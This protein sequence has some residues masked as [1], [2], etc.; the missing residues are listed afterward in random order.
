MSTSDI[1]IKLALEGGQ[2]LKT[3]IRDAGLSMR[4]LGSELKKISSQMALTKNKQ[5]LMKQSVQNLGK[6]FNTQKGNVKLVNQQFTE[7]KQ[8][9]DALEKEY[10]ELASAQGENSKETQQAKEKWLEASRNVDRYSQKLNQAETKLNQIELELRQTQQELIKTNIEESKFG[11]INST[12]TGIQPRLNAVAN[13]FM[14]ITKAITGVAMGLVGLSL[15]KA[16]AKLETL[17]EVRA[18]FK[19]LGKDTKEIQR[20]MDA[21]SNS[22]TGTKY[23]MA[24]M[25][26][27]SKGADASIGNYSMSMEDYLSRIADISAFTG[28]SVTQTGTM[29][30]KAM[31]KNRVDARLMNQLI[32]AGIPIYDDLARVTGKSTAEISEMVSAGQIGFEDL[33]KATERYKDLA[34]ELGM[35]TLKG[36]GTILAQTWGNVGVAFLEGAYEPMRK[37]LTNIVLWLK[38]NMDQIKEWGASFGNAINYLINYVRTGEKDMKGL[39]GVA[40]KIAGTLRPFITIVA[41]LV[42]AFMNLST[43]GKVAVLMIATFTA[44]VLKLA[45][46]M[47]TLSNNIQKCYTSFMKHA[48][49]VTFDA[50]ATEVSN[51]EIRRAYIER[52]KENLATVK[53][54]VAKGL[55]TVATTSM[56]VATRI[57][58]TAQRM[59]NRVMMMNPYVLVAGAILTV[60]SALGIFLASNEEARAKVSSFFSGFIKNAKTIAKNFPETMDSIVEALSETLP[61]MVSAGSEMI[62]SIVEGFMQNL[63]TMVEMGTQ[64]IVKLIEGFATALPNMVAGIT[65]MI[66]QFAIIIT[67]NLPLIINAGLKILMSLIQGI[68]TALPMLIISAI[69]I[70]T[71]LIQGIG[72]M[73][74]TILATG[75]KL[76]MAI[77]KGIIQTIPVLIASIPKIISAIVKT[78]IKLSA[79]L[80]TAGA[81]I[82]K[83][84][85][86]GFRGWVGAFTSN[87]AGVFRSLPSRIRGWLGSL[88]SI[89]SNWIKGLWSGISNAKEW[90]WNKI[91]GVISGFKDRV[92]K[93]FKIKSPSRVMADEVGKF[94][95]L[96]I[97]VGFEQ[98]MKTVGVEMQSALDSA[99]LKTDGVL[100]TASGSF[101][102]DF[103]Y[104][105]LAQAMS[106]QGIYLDGRL[107]G[108]A[109]NNNDGVVAI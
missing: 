77:I 47:I 5:D 104:D 70:I 24:D 15:T 13:G 96:G 3:G 19:G 69:R 39:D 25:A 14:K 76:L 8:K 81:R 89:G 57:G 74:P 80:I 26:K 6:Q 87:V 56:T 83:N 29:F 95:A 49:A 62:V 109:I 106:N 35:S 102:A 42:K 54:T 46:G 22:V 12:L 59:M 28:Q 73:I 36:A 31:A 63:P 88:A 20:L 48:G 68:I 37:G 40:R 41:S 43:H 65:K 2:E 72:Q 30:N 23:G 16:F 91:K 17:E 32:Q 97:G 34:T 44:P 7:A 11:R 33:Y 93:F 38:S 58:A 71:A 99:M 27:V 78:L 55:N 86:T 66:T 108:R 100:A 107:I 53:N 51:K 4:N 64:L 75:V 52:Q 50:E 61:E 84:I 105:E 92:K 10:R 9:A 45:S 103:D 98:G 85:W 101:L 21:V 90:V 94:L 67:Q 79:Q 18:T 82:L 60:V 1:T